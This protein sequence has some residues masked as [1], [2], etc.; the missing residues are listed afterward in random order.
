[1]IKPSVVMY[2][3]MFGFSGSKSRFIFGSGYPGRLLKEKVKEEISIGT[4]SKVIK[5]HGILDRGDLSRRKMMNKM[6]NWKGL[7][8]LEEKAKR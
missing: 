4:K 6:R 5:I 8:R 7:K 3:W 2:S 1:M